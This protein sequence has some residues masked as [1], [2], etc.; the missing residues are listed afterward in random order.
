MSLDVA[1]VLLEHQAIDQDRLAEQ[2]AGSYAWSR[3]Y[4]PGTARQLKLVKRGTHWPEARSTV[5]KD[6]SFGNGAAMRSPPVAL[7][8]YNDFERLIAETKKAAAVTHAHPLAIQ[9]A[10]AISIVIYFALQGRNYPEMWRLLKE[11]CA[12]PVF[13]TKIGLAERWADGSSEIAKGEVVKL[14]GNGMAAQDSV[15]T[16]IY[17]AT[18]FMSR[19]F[20]EMISFI[21][22]F[23]G[24]VDTIG[25]MAGAIWGA[26]NGSATLE[27][28]P[29]EARDQLKWVAMELY[30]KRL[31][32]FIC[33]Q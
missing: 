32:P 28:I 6:G 30:K 29:V 4:G 8:F 15:V 18:R 9:G 14:L 10:V 19:S 22:S 24:D 31:P 5:F 3:G 17:A 26:A 2:F 21:I 12:S 13:S 25:A 16:A 11:R 1:Q 7:F 33:G 27:G 23:K 20:G